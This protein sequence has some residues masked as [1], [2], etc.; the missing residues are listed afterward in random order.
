MSGNGSADQLPLAVRTQGV[1]KTF[2][3]GD[4]AVRALKGVDFEARCGEL[5]MLE[6]G[7]A[8]F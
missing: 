2:G 7:R 6:I 1:T 5:I 3:R 4:N 8:H